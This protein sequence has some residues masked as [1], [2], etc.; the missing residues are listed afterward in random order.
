LTKPFVVVIPALES[1]AEREPSS[2][3]QPKTVAEAIAH[4]REARKGVTL[5]GLKIRDF[6]HE[7]R[8][9]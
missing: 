8:K 1:L 9:Y 5:G 2:I 4:I 3:E 7:G 6:I